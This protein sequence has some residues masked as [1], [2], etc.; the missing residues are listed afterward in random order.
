ML[1][2]LMVL[3]M[4]WYMSQIKCEKQKYQKVKLI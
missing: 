4:K 2:M 3:F 1:R